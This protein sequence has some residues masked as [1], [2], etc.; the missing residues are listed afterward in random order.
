MPNPVLIRLLEQRQQQI[1]FITHLLEQVE[2]EARDLV[3]AETSNLNAAKERIAQL[4]A[5]IKPLQEYEA[6]REAHQDTV[7]H[8][9]QPG[10]RRER[11]S[12]GVKEPDPVAYDSAGAFLVDLVRSLRYESREMAGIYSQHAADR[13]S[14][15]L[16][17]AAGDVEPGP[18]QTT[19]DTPGLLP[20]PIIGE[21]QSDLDGLRPLINTIGAKDLSGIP[22]KSFSRPMVTSHPNT[23][24][25]KQAAEKAEGQKG[26]VKIEGKDFTKESFLRWMN[27]SRQEIDWTAP[28]AWDILISEMLAVYAEDTEAD[29]VAK[30]NAA[31][32][33]TTALA[34]DDIEGWI[35]ALYAARGVIVTKNGTAKARIRRIPD[36][37]FVSHDMDGEVSALLDIHFA[38]NFNPAGTGALDR[39]GGELVR[40]PRVMLPDLPEG[41]VI[42][43]RKSGF[44]FYEQRIGLLQAVEPKVLGV[45]IAYG[46]YAAAGALDASLFAKITAP[47]GP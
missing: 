43:G 13:V 39:F 31:V 37:I 22:G 36:T 44:E 45:Q 41:T 40:T 26:E 35:K 38:T 18:H 29:A 23:G 9:N 28:A 27:V 42:Y 12:L 24:S 10:P 20:K 34:T 47:A 3:D 2:T 7:A 6:T 33:Q 21:V 32:T 17:R 15:A 5:Q 1:D 14:S 25:G 8:I 19:E 30:L 4:D 46:G 16:G 11:T